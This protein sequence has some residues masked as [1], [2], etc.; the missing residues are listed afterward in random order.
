MANF[1]TIFFSLILGVTNP[2]E[3]KKT[4]IQQEPV[5]TYYLIRHAEKD[6]SDSSNRNPNLKKEGLERAKKWAEV[7]KDIDLDAVYSTDY[8][9]TMQ[10]AKPLADLN[11]LNIIKYDASK[12]FDE[13]FEKATKGKTVLVVGHSNTTPQ[14]ANAILGEKKYEDL[15]DSENGA[16][17]IVQIMEDGT[18]LSQVIYIN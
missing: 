12:L 3:E 7:L 9:R 2:S 6:R 1:I 8:N 15:D 18:T 16:L 4:E 13:N 17:L 5:S 11:K 10:T 14:F